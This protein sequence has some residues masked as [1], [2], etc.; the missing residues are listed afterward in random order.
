[1]R[2]DGGALHPQ[3]EVCVENALESKNGVRHSSAGLLH[4]LHFLVV[5]LLKIQVVEPRFLVKDPAAEDHVGRLCVGTVSE[6]LTVHATLW[7][8]RVDRWSFRAPTDGAVRA[9]HPILFRI[10]RMPSNRCLLISGIS[11]CFISLSSSSA[12]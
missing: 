12:L 7:V 1:M 3:E 6:L 10:A 2:P 4:T 11:N 9:L 5:L 8:T